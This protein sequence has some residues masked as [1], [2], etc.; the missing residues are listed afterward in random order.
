MDREMLYRS[1]FV[2]QKKNCTFF[3]QTRVYNNF[4][5]KFIRMQF[6]WVHFSLALEVLELQR[7][8]IK[9]T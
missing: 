9:P 2:M 8:E 3:L 7:K 5:V 1:L 6:M 4:S